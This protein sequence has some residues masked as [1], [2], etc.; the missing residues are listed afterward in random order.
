MMIQRVLRRLHD[1]VNR[2]MALSSLKGLDRIE[3]F[4]SLNEAAALYRFAAS[5]HRN[6]TIIEIGCWKGKSTYCLAKGLRLGKIYVIDPF[7]C[8]G[9]E[10]SRP[11]YLRTMGCKPLRQQFSDV[12]AELG[13][14]QKIKVLEGLSSQ[15][16][17]HVRNADMLFI[18]GDHSVE[19]CTFDFK[20]YA[21]NLKLGGLLLIHDYDASRKTLGPTWIIENIIMPSHDYEYI[22]LYD[23]L[24]VGRKIRN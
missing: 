12:M 3:G 13:V 16:V 11:A 2:K 20:H 1:R 9:D 5:L 7:N 21:P 22:G 4:L 19:W 14:S 6:S 17:D 18:D 8:A 10:D 24:W 15:F 23:S